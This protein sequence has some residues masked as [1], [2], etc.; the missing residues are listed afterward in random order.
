[1][2]AFR[3]LAV[4]VLACCATLMAQPPNPVP[5]L[6]QPLQP[7][8]IAAG[9]AAFTLTVNG[10]GFAPGSVVQWNT[11]ARS[12]IFISKSQLT[13][14]IQASDI[15]NGGTASVTVVNPAPGG[16]TSNI[17]SFAIAVAAPVVSLEFVSPAGVCDSDSI[18]TADFNHDGKMDIA[19]VGSG[20]NEAPGVIC[21]L[22][23][24]GDGSFQPYTSYSAGFFTRG[25]VSGDLNGD[26]RPDLVVVNEDDG[27]ISVF[28]GNGDGTFQPAV[29]SPTVLVPVSLTLGDFNGDGRLDAAIGTADGMAIQ[30]GNGDGTFQSPIAF[31]SGVETFY[32]V[33]G[34]F[35]RDGR[36]DIAATGNDFD[37]ISVF[38]G[39]GDGTFQTNVNYPTLS[40]SSLIF[41]GDFNGD[42]A[43]DL[44]YTDGGFLSLML[45][46]GDGT[47]QSHLDY[48]LGLSDRAYD[49]GFGDV[50]ADGKLDALVATTETSGAN[51]FQIY[52][53]N[54]DGTFA[55][56]QTSSGSFAPFAFA[57]FNNDGL[58]DVV[59]LPSPISLSL[60]L[61]NSVSLS[62]ASLAFDERLVN[63]TSIP[64]KIALTNTGSKPTNFSGITFTGDKGFTQSNNCPPTILSGHSCS[65]GVSFAPTSGAGPVNGTMVIADT[66]LINP[67]S[68]SLS[69][70][71]E[72]FRLG[73]EP[74]N[75]QTISPGFSASY[76]IEIGSVGN[77]AGNVQLSCGHAPESG[78]C[79]ISPN[80]FTFTESQ[81]FK[82]T[83]MVTTTSGTPL[84]TYTIEIVGHSAKEDARE[85]VTLI[86]D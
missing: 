40:R 78:S 38:L 31:G 76:V 52:L 51:L 49:L 24:N 19:A 83:L 17:V 79:T 62:A 82:S 59:T 68:V 56:P 36:L 21:V 5:F 48:S 23:G 43:L 7:G 47:F 81:T 28:L 14:A 10:A 50:N 26:G 46:N 27:T 86:V 37:F 29:N 16:G 13:A 65:I 20:G 64:Q 15:A 58:M 66:A 39:N 63:T 80:S 35:N 53:G 30:L 22:L 72:G 75:T 4:F 11:S 1:M 74:P 34:D 25:L 41:T 55:A 71:T 73:F 57:D 18:I 61:Q 45:G 77:F 67:Q 8:H 69:G 60:F 54:G 42:G 70:Y 3:G 85:G 12:T 32:M 44:A 2:R 33:T 84:G 9:G 6:N